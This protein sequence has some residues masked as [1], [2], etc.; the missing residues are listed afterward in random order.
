MSTAR[1]RFFRGV[2]ALLSALIVSVVACAEI[3]WVVVGTRQ[4]GPGRGISMARFDLETGALSIP[5]LVFETPQPVFWVPGADPRHLYFCHGLD[6][7]DGR[8]E[9][10]ISAFLVDAEAGALTL[11]NQTS[12]GGRGA[13]HVNLD[14]T[15]R[16]LLEASYRSGHVAVFSLRGDGSIGERASLLQ[17]SGKSV[18]PDRQTSAHPHSIYPDPTNRFVLV[19]DLGL[20][21]IVIYRFDPTFGILLPHD[22]GA[23][24]LPAGSGP[25]HLAWHP[26]GRHAYVTQELINA[27]TTFAWDADSGTLLPLQTISTLPADFSGQNTASEIAVHPSGRYIYASNR[28]SDNTI[29]VFA[30]D[31]VSALLTPVDRV[32][33]RGLWPR[34]FSIDRTGRWMVV[35]NHDSDSL[36]VFAIDP[37]SGRLAAVG[38]PVAAPNPFGTRFLER[39]P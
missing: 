11:I 8:P 23:V 37:V 18:H 16:W 21:K 28:G 1:C 20:D 39:R 38:E 32:S 35:S 36:V 25:R 3:C 27:V 17:H 34:N 9:G 24:E 19:P 22:P 15:G 4:D 30:V 26:D 10:F 13:S 14:Q 12:I 31:P 7:F 2:A 6:Q 5:R 29:A 33:S